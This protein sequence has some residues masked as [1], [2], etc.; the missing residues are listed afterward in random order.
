MIDQV[1]VEVQA[2]DGGAGAVSFRREKF[3][4]RGGPDGGHG[5]RGGHVIV[6]ANGQ[7]NTLRRYRR[8][9][10]FRAEGGAPGG[11]NNRH[12]RDGSDLVLEVP[13]G[14][15]VSRIAEGEEAA[16]RV[17][18]LAETGQGVV[19]AEGG[20]GGRGNASFKSPTNRAPRV[21]QRG[22]PGED[23]RLLLELRLIADVGLIGLPNAGKSTLLAQ[24][25]AARPRVAAYPFTTLE[26]NLG[27]V[28]NGW[29]EF[30]VADLPGLIEGAADGAGLGHDFLRHITRTR[31]LVHLI[32]GAEPDPAA[33]YEMVRRELGAYSEGLLERPELIV[34]NK[35]DLAAVAERRAELATAFATRGVEAAFISAASGEGI[36]E[37][38]Q[39][40]AG[41]LEEA[42]EASAKEAPEPV[43]LRPK[44]D[45]HRFDVAR[46]RG[47]TYRIRGRGVERFVRMMDLD[48]GDARDEVYRWLERRGVAAALRRAGL[49]R[50]DRVRIGEA[51][52]AW[53]T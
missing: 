21:A 19:L 53:E 14:T 48:D 7:I 18:D 15:V 12:G 6:V 1:E 3:V 43:V 50:G 41:L 4:P 32:D 20:H 35:L 8:Q 11:T 40:C 22:E 42:R 52:W 5:G 2:G 44:G 17:A 49:E 37:L 46:T 51:E 45:G 24:L 29:E 31:V 9:R 34:I 30:V 25:S 13:T 28:A 36:E 39:R 33:A 26:P 23:V 16:A 27:V 10:Q 47:G 38:T